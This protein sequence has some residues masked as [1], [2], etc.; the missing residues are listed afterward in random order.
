MTNALSL[1]DEMKTY[2][3]DD[4]AKI[5][6]VKVAE[7]MSSVLL[8][9]VRQKSKDRVQLLKD[10]YTTKDVAE[11]FGCDTRRVSEACC[12]GRF[13][14]YVRYEYRGRGKFGGYHFEINGV[15][16]LYRECPK[17]FVPARKLLEVKA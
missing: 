9:A 11:M 4:F 3:V 16:Q 15:N 6:A 17:H 5:V 8:P 13:P 2:T 14:P 12:Y 7:E 1:F 10:Y